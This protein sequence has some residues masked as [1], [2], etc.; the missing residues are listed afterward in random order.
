M[1]FFVHTPLEVNGIQEKARIRWT[2]EVVYRVDETLV[3][4]PGP[5]PQTCYVSRGHNLD[6]V[7]VFNGNEANSGRLD[8][9]FFAEDEIGVRF[10]LGYLLR[11][12]QHS[13]SKEAH[14]YWNKVSQA[15]ALSGGLFEASP[16]EI[17]GNMSNIDD[18]SEQ[19]FGYF[20]AS[21]EYELTRF[22]TPDQAGNPEDF[23]S[24]DLFSG[25]Q[26]CLSCLTI[27]FS[28]QEIPD[29]WGQ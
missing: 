21:E 4:G 17:V 19:V 7:V 1:Q 2:F 13:L 22:V 25:E 16:G 6:K 29:D 20:Y 12:N 5:G 23:C 26:V 28:T 24:T 27:P 3:P 11:I 15:V 18:P 8:K 9:F 10:G 14:E